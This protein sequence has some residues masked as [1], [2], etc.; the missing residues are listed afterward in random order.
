MNYF[1]SLDALL[2]KG[3]GK[4][5]KATQK[6]AASTMQADDAEGKL[7][8]TIKIRHELLH[9]RCNSV[10]RSRWYFEYYRRYHLDPTH[11][12]LRAVRQCLRNDPL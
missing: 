9:G 3:N 10:E 11:G 7:D 6:R 8:L 5:D 2:G 12:L 4:W 1:I